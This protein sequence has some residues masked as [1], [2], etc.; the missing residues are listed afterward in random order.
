VFVRDT[1]TVPAIVVEL[2][3]AL[4]LVVVTD[5]IV[6]I[7]LIPVCRVV[8]TNEIAVILVEVRVV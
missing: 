7:V 3:E 1:D 4:V 6:P 8:S 2:S 5:E